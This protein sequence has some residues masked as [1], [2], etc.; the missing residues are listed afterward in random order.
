MPGSSLRNAVKRITH[1]ERSQPQARAHL[2][3]LEK[4]KDYRKRADNYHRKE[5]RVQ[6]MQRKASMRNPD[7]FYF[8]MHNAQVKEGH[9]Q[10]TE[11][12]RRKELEDTLGA[13]AVRVMKDQDLSYVR[14][15]KQRDVKK[16]ERLRESLHLIGDNSSRKKAKHIVFVDSNEKAHAFDVAKHFD[17]VPELVGR[18]FNRPRKSQLRAR[19]LEQLGVA[20]DEDLD[21]DSEQATT[22]DLK[23]QE[24]LARKSARRAAK[25]RSNAYGELEART[26]RAAAMEL[27]EAHLTTEKLVAGKGRK[28]KIKPAEDGRPAQY[29][30]RRKRNR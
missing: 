1:K 29:K 19:A 3:T 30:W 25:A 17:T 26:R 16:A 2:G 5:E 20:N 13:D 11:E 7:E 27:A 24:K 6:A 15:Q 12:A 14:L 21:F 9:H 18:S 4:K 23:W 28:R 22:G 8:G 10:Q